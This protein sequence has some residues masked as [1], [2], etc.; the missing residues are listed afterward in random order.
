MLDDSF[1]AEDDVLGSGDE[2]SSGDFV[3]GVL[4]ASGK[5]ERMSMYG[6]EE[7]ERESEDGVYNSTVSMNAALS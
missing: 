6:C 4:C 5:Y 3:P 1:P 2:G 7:R